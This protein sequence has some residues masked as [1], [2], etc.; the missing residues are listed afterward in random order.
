MEPSQKYIIQKENNKENKEAICAEL[1]IDGR[2][3]VQDGL[4]NHR[5]NQ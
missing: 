1:T 5:H 3:S 2:D 4:E